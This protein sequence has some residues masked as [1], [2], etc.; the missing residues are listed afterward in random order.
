MQ[1]SGPWLRRAFSR[2]RFRS[3]SATPL[4][5]PPSP[6]ELPD[7]QAL[8][9]ERDRLQRLIN[10]NSDWLWEVD[11]QGRYVFVSEHSRHLLG[12]APEQMLGHTPFDFMPPEE[13]ARVG[14]IFGGIIAGK[15][16]FSGL[17]NRNRRADGRMVILETSGIPLL[18]ED[19]TLLGYRGIDRDVTERE[20]RAAR[21]D[22]MARH[23]A[24]T[25]LGNRP[26]FLSRLDAR[27]ASGE[28]QP[29]TAVVLLD[30]D[31]FKEVNDRLGHAS[32]DALLRQLAQRLRDLLPPGS[33]G[34]RLGGDEFA[35]M[36]ADQD[37]S[38]AMETATAIVGSLAAPYELEGRQAVIGVS[39]GLA[40]APLHARD[41][42]TL[43][44]RADLA[45]YHAKHQGRGRVCLYSAALEVSA[46]A[47]EGL[48]TALRRAVAEEVIGALFQPFYAARERRMLGCA[49]LPSW[50]CAEAGPVAP[51]VFLPLAEKTGL[52]I[53]LGA[54]LL[55]QACEAARQWPPAL[56]VQVPASA[57]QLRDPH[58]PALV[59]DTLQASGLAPHRLRISVTEAMLNE[60]QG[61]AART[62]CKL[63]ALGVSVALDSFGDSAMAVTTLLSFPFDRLRLGGAPVRSVATEPS[64][65]VAR[66]L[67]GLA[68][69]LG[70]AVDMVG[71]QSPQQWR[72]A[73]ELG[74]EEVQGELL[75]AP[76]AAPL[77]LEEL[78][79]APA[80]LA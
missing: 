12:Y 69:R 57:V 2:L 29:R 4:P 45:L 37:V 59:E 58:F 30:L 33:L 23:D 7:R 19:G 77:V 5:A 75:C 64:A 3:T 61:A 66:A 62:L 11:A 18:A 79:C 80:P 48:E 41:G 1:H 13:A 28:V 16:P 65:S 60:A 14:A 44:R 27:M 35:V 24:L 31:F 40:L 72:A 54:L 22:Y 51:E 15:Q 50:H 26:E 6:E 34:G 53:P 38:D 74:C 46:R 43:L 9:R 20:E 36:L 25:G 52:I 70:M 17:L 8:A 49:V 67:T 71:V 32:G 78:F 76:R 73:L 21:I 55:R 39:A 42:A 56:R 47:A 63:R 10:T 68:L